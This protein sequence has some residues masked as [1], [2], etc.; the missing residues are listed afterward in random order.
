MTFFT[1]KFVIQTLA[2]FIIA[3]AFAVILGVNRRHLLSVGFGGMITGVVYYTVFF[4]AHSLFFAALI[5]TMST[6]LYVEVLART[7]RAP[8]IVFILP[9]VTPTVPGGDLYKGMK[10]LISGNLSGSLQNFGNTFEIG[11]G[12][13]GGIVTVSVI[14]A[15]IM[16]GVKKRKNRKNKAE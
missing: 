3:I 10:D 2:A 1:Q 14:F 16:D 4:F 12:I 11:L 6:S 13:A 15:I 8:T 7:R 5:S 9:A